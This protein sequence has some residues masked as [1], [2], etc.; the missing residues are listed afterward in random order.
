MELVSRFTEQDVT[1]LTAD[2]AFSTRALQAA[3]LIPVISYF[4][5]IFT[6]SD[7]YCLYSYYLE[8]YL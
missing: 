5:M 3:Q 6:F 2:T 1:P 7:S 8:Y 4:F